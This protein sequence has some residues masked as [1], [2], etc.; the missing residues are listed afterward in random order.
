M[1][2]VAEAKYF[3]QRCRDPAIKKLRVVECILTPCDLVR[4]N[5]NFIIPKEGFTSLVDPK[6]VWD[7]PTL[8]S[9][10]SPMSSGKSCPLMGEPS[11]IVNVLHRHPGGALAHLLRT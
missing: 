4:L 9:S 7:E 8:L 10:Q 5:F 2:I 6:E 11:E 3:P 1:Q